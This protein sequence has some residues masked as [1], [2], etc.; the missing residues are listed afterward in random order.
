[1]YSWILS[2]ILMQTVD[3]ILNENTLCP[4]HVADM[5]RG[6][7]A[8]SPCLI[9]LCSQFFFFLEKHPT[10]AELQMGERERI[11]AQSEFTEKSSRSRDV[12]ISHRVR[13]QSLLSP[14][15]L[16]RAT[17]SQILYITDS[18]LVGKWSGCFP[19]LEK[20]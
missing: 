20:P 18:L 16:E 13:L 9:K 19:T 2:S 14:A 7:S 17:H 8:A 3:F 5:R 1:M 12:N 11:C 4:D 6:V 10:V 15:R